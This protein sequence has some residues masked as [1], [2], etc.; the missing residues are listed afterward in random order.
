MKILFFSKVVKFTWKIRNQLNRKKNWISDFLIS[1]FRVIFGHFE[2]QFLVILVLKSF[3][4]SMNFHD[5]SKNRNRKNQKIGI[6]FD[7][8][9][10]VSFMKVSSKLSEG[11]KGVCISLVGTID[12]RRYKL[13]TLDI[14]GTIT[15]I[16]NSVSRLYTMWNV[17]KNNVSR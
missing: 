2:F 1:I 6:S 15:F 11:V 10:Y 8:A 3:Q 16:Y 14:T 5:I 13:L 7:S 12:K 9:H 17:N 4:F